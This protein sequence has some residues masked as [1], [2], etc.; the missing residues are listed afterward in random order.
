MDTFWVDFQEI[1]F[2][3]A[4]PGLLLLGAGF[5]AGAFLLAVFEVVLSLGRRFTG[6]G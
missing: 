5:V 1:V 3:V 4:G 6:R 2:L